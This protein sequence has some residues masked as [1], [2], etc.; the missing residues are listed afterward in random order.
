MNPARLPLRAVV[1]LLVV[2]SALCT[3]CVGLPD[4]GQIEVGSDGQSSNQD[5]GFPY[6]P[7]PPQAGESPVDIVRHFL[8]AM[9]A[10]PSST[11]VAREFLTS[12]GGEAWQPER[13]MITYRDVGT[14]AGTSKVRV[15]LQ[16]ANRLDARGV[17]QGSVPD[18][19]LT[20]PMTTEDAQWRIARAPNAMIVSDSW[21]EDRYR[22]VS[23]FFFD[24]TGQVLVPEP[25]YV[26]RGGQLATVLMR[27]LLEGPVT[28]TPG[29]A[30][31]FIPP[32][33]ALDELSVP[34]SAEGVAQVSL[35]GD[36]SQLDPESVELMTVQMAWTLR[37]DPSVQRVRVTVGGTPITTSGS[38]SDFSV[39]TGQDYDPNGPYSWQDLFGLRNGRLVS[40]IEGEETRAGGLLGRGSYDLRDLAVDLGSR[41]VVGVTANGTGAVLTSVERERGATLEPIVTGATDL[42]KPAWDHA[43]R[44]WV[45]DRSVRGAEVSVFSGGRL[46][47]VRVPGVSG[48][49]VRDFL[50]S[51]DGTRLIAV[52][53]R[54]GTDV[55]VLSRLAR[56]GPTATATPA[57]PILNSIEEPMRIRDIAWNSPTEIIT[58]RAISKDLSQVTT[59]S[60][61]GSS[62]LHSGSLSSELVR[63]N[64]VRLVSSPLVGSTGYAVAADGTMYPLASE[65]DA[66]IP[67]EGL[68]IPTYVG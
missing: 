27:G 26:P 67:E 14:P 41:R 10:N 13:G 20:F 21:F 17:W 24:P 64:I 55:V 4:D 52:V 63:A 53:R 29:V 48:A 51:R 36:I 12:S 47:S 19:T 62:S 22:Q 1:P 33:L 34:V 2:L 8:D 37:Q 32:G 50:V 16:G 65:V 45:V 25:V 23:L 6:D 49:D 59:L 56:K 31:S 5:S 44:I 54:Q 3:A 7:R 39:D 60:V 38:G 66:D 57:R 46:R 35:R 9:W 30:Q 68:R 42:L 15:R 58:T 18:P 40:S 28:T 43:G 61:D 11:S